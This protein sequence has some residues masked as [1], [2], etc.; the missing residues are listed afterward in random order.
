MKRLFCFSILTCAILTGLM[1][2]SGTMALGAEEGIGETGTDPRDF[3]P[4]F[5][6]YYRFTELENGLEQQEFVLFG[7]YAF[8]PKFAMTYEIPLA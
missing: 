4:K 5:M 6:P 1:I 3:A 7:M 8:A 2:F